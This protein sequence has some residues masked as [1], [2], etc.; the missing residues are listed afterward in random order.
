MLQSINELQGYTLRAADG[1]AGRVADFY[2][3]D[4]RWIVEHLVLDIGAWL[5]RRQV[6]LPPLAI[7]A[8]DRRG[9][10]VEAR[11]TTGQIEAS[12]DK[13]THRPVPYQYEIESRP[14]TVEEVESGDPRLHSTEDVTGYSIGARDGEIGKVKDFLADDVDWT[15]RYLVVD[16]GGWWAGRQVLVAPQWIERAYWRRRTVAVDLL[17]GEIEHSP[18]F[19]PDQPIDRQ[20]E[21]RLHAHYRRPAYWG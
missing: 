12:P 5:P 16:T 4:E 19:D 7:R 14:R 2:F 11:L 17:R 1:D 3:N 13:N 6:L 8:V 9:R 10:R 15:I 18:T 21:A 20:Y